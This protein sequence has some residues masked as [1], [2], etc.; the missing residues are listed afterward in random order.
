MSHGFS[1]IY[2]DKP[3]NEGLDS[4]VADYLANELKHSE[5]TERII[6]AAKA[7]T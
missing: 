4:G 2:T 5:L 6:G 7:S 1:R 3:T